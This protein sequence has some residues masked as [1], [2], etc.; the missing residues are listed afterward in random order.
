MI[1][2]ADYPGRETDHRP[3][4]RR[5]CHHLST[6]YD[7]PKTIKKFLRSEI[8]S[9]RDHNEKVFDLVSSGIYP[10]SIPGQLT[11]LKMD[12]RTQDITGMLHRWS[13][14]DRDSLDALMPAI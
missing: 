10:A 12:Q 9:C 11:G 3:A 6:R 1:P 5:D 14:G 7:K 13:E 2:I 8:F 4:S